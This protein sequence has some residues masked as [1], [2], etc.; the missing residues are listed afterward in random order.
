ML[1]TI[2]Q[3]IFDIISPPQLPPSNTPPTH[4]PEHLV[5]ALMHCSHYLTDCNP[6]ITLLP[7]P[8]ETQPLQNLSYA[9]DFSFNPHEPSATSDLLPHDTWRLHVELAPADYPYTRILASLSP[10]YTPCFS[11]LNHND[12]EP[13]TASQTIIPLILPS[14]PLTSSTAMGIALPHALN[15]ALLNLYTPVHPAAQKNL[16]TIPSYA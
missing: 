10:I 4:T 1:Q 15:T 3:Q 11:D 12:H 16:L 2:I 7:N 14:Y 9:V 5:Q 8:I 6:N 13:S